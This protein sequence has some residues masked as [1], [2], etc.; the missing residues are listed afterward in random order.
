M[1][2]YCRYVGFICRAGITVKSARTM[3]T[4]NLVHKVFFFRGPYFLYERTH[5]RRRNSRRHDIRKISNPFPVIYNATQISKFPPPPMLY[6]MDVRGGVAPCG[7]SIYKLR[8]SW[9][10]MHGYFS[11]HHYLLSF[12]FVWKTVHEIF[13]ILKRARQ[14]SN[15]K[16]PQSSEN[17]NAWLGRNLTHK[18][19]L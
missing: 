5:S 19:M 6:Y 4:G 17:S 10:G 7:M 9:L 1:I 16:Q 18:F 15:C 13:D 11:P 3:H 14:C 12:L 8:G 2:L